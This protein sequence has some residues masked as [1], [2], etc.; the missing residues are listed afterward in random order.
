MVGSFLYLIPVTVSVRLAAGRGTSSESAVDGQW[1]D[2][3][4]SHASSSARTPE[5]QDHVFFA[6]SEHGDRHGRPAPFS[7]PVHVGV[8]VIERV[9]ARRFRA[10]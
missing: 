5:V 1:I 10:R 9:E 6:R 2:R 4:R 3:D 7:P 8:V